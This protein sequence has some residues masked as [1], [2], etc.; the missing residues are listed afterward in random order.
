MSEA[1]PTCI[2]THSLTS[3]YKQHTN[4]T[5][6]HSFPITTSIHRNQTLPSQKLTWPAHCSFPYTSPPLPSSSCLGPSWCRQTPSPQGVPWTPPSPSAPTCTPSSAPPWPPPSSPRSDL[7]WTAPCPCE[8]LSPCWPHRP[9]GMVCCP[10]CGSKRFGFC[11]LLPVEKDHSSVHANHLLHVAHPPPPP[12]LPSGMVCPSCG[13]R[14]KRTKIRLLSIV[15][16]RKRPLFCPCKPP[17]PC[18]PPPHPP[19]PS[20]MVCPS[21]GNR[22]KRTKIRLLSIVTSRKRPLFCP[23]VPP[24]PCWPH[25]PNEM[26]CCLSCA[27]RRQTT[28]IRL[29]SIAT[30]RKDRSSVHANHL[31]P[32]GPAGQAEWPVV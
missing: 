19:L 32:V 4:A 27:S 3:H 31:L 12:P 26:A 17:S 5:Y 21:C 11:Q 2:R 7:V 15:T 1:L 24:S 28:K 13:N 23:C 20:G 18:C 6:S 8:P 10:S 25:L 9:G 16:S 30:C 14:R 29:L 22:R